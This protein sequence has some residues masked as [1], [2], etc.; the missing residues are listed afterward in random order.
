[1]RV[2][3]TPYAADWFA[4]SLRWAAALGVVAA[5]A[6]DA[7]LFVSSSWLVA[8]I[9]AWNLL[10]TVLASVNTRIPF[11][12]HVNLAVDVALAY[13]LFVSKDGLHGP[14]A[15]V[16]ILPVLTG[17]VY[18]EVLGGG[19]TAVLFAVLALVSEWSV[20]AAQPWAAM[21]WFGVALALGL[22]FG[23]LGSGLMR[24]IRIRRQAWLNAEEA[25]HRIQRER[26]R[27]IYELSSSLTATLSYK[28]VLDSALDMGYTALNPEAGGG[29][30]DPL[31]S[32]VLLF[33]GGKLKVGSAR[34]FTSADQR[35]ILDGAD[36]ILKRVFD[37]GEPVL[38]HDV[39]SDPEL[40]RFI[41]L[42]NC[43]SVYCFP[44]RTGFNI[45]GVII[46]AHPDAAYFTSIRRDLLDI[47][48]KQTVIAIQNARLYQDL[49]EEKERMMEVYEEAR[50]KL[51][52]DLHDGP[53]QSIAAM[54]MRMSIARRMMASDPGGTEAELLKIQELAQRAGK[55][56]RHT[57]FTL[58]PL[59]LET[60]GLGAALNS[61][62]E[63]MRDT[64]DQSV[65]V[66]IDEQQA[67]EIETG[68]QGILFYIVEEALSNARKHAKAEN[69]WIRL[70]NFQPGI[71]L[72]EVEDDGV[73][74]DV[75]LVEKAYDTRSSLGLINL[76]ERT[77]LINGVLDI[78]STIGRGTRIS[79]YVPLT[80]EAG[81]RL[82]KQG[83]RDARRSRR[84][85]AATN[86]N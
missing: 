12:R 30:V 46:F 3:E 86:R 61:L 81:E 34:R 22:L 66:N 71:A 43:R 40:E 50:K 9:L 60:Q 14:L 77:E 37:E 65:L 67:S 1:M 80:R 75:A 6:L 15:W 27:A 7:S 31:V 33:R 48:A 69:I 74:F 58:R 45:Y 64:F 36:G 35:V 11:H 54:A 16:G 38:S 52:R 56:I 8:L 82:H 28:R 42:R 70:R 55:E 73:G 25:K 2:S 62:A 57:L 19:A 78:E 47:I 32:A 21:E 24:H 53:T 85:A 39:A 49:L 13:M 17:S 59:V 20:A 41:A 5:L 10:M 23:L 26:L 84:E 83:E 63:K 72:L 79:V 4:I 76:R 44:L 18:F 68:K 51:A 29:S